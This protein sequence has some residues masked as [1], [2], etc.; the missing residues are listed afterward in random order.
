MTSGRYELD[1]DDDPDND[2]PAPGMWS[3]FGESVLV[4]CPLCQ[5]VAALDHDVAS[6]GAVSPS[7]VCPNDSACSWHV[8]ARLVG[9]T[10]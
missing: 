7:L 6:D 4:R 10:G 3:K 9:W 2:G 1:F 8:V 5:T